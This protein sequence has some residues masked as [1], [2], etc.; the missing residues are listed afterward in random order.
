MTF[1]ICLSK[2][3]SSTL[4]L[5]D[6]WILVNYF[7]MIYI[8]Y[9]FL[10]KDWKQVKNFALQWILNLRRMFT[11]KLNKHCWTFAWGCFVSQLWQCVFLLEMKSIVCSTDFNKSW[12]SLKVHQWKNDGLQSSRAFISVQEVRNSG[13]NAW[14]E[15]INFLDCVIAF[16]GVVCSPQYFALT[17]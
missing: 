6:H 10:S 3:I 1:V 16:T 15:L 17:A 8:S 7:L 14:K 2:Q 9:T 4:S 12:F 13:D 5:S 11:V